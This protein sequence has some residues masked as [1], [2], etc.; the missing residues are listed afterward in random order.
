M[1][2]FLSAC[3]Y[4]NLNWLRHISPTCHNTFLLVYKRYEATSR[5]SR[6][7][8]GFNNCETVAYRHTH[9]TQCMESGNINCYLSATLT[10]V[11]FIFP[12]FFILS[13]L[14]HAHILSIAPL[15]LA[16]PN[17]YK[18]ATIYVWNKADYIVAW[19]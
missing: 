11:S 9:T 12:F 3:D 2:S 4:L 8:N 10:M 17:E 19:M 7:E 6:V 14:L 18:Q 13:S 15:S 5:R 16:K 1:V